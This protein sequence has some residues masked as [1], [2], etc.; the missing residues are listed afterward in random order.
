MFK[1]VGDDLYFKGVKFATMNIRLVPSFRD[2]VE[3]AIKNN[4]Y[5]DAEI[6][7]IK[8]AVR[9]HEMDRE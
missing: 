7:E 6:K 5:S 1:I 8:D 9:K 2:E 3:N 4:F